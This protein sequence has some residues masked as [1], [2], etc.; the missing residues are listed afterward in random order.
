MVWCMEDICHKKWTDA[1][2]LCSQ[3]HCGVV[4]G[5]NLQKKNKKTKNKNPQ[6]HKKRD[7]C[8]VSVF[9]EPLWCGVWRK[10]LPPPPPKKKE[11]N[12]NKQT[13]KKNPGPMLSLCVHRT[14]VVWC[15]E[16][17]CKKTNKPGT[18]AKSLCSQNHCG[19]EYGGNLPQKN[20]RKTG[21]ILSLCV[22]RTTVVRCMEEI[23]HKKKTH[24]KTG[25]ML[26]LCVHRTTVVWCMEEICNQK[27]NNK[28]QKAK[29][30][31]NGTDAKS[32]CSQNHCGVVYG[33]ICHQKT[34]TKQD[35]C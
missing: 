13:T 34:P 7:R 8:S 18:D 16:E 20:T 19:V 21:P 26:S 11:T 30:Q 32:L 29:K 1:Q 6:K 12:K 25:P 31:K 14:T 27:K 28:K 3:S 15:M 22:H 10:S 33:E 24:K 35:R 4:Y 23:C 17:I 9:T 2:S 5:G